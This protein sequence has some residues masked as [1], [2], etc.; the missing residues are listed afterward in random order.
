MK[1]NPQSEQSSS[2]SS[3]PPSTGRNSFVPEKINLG[4]NK[5]KI[6]RGRH[7]GVADGDDDKADKNGDGGQKKMVGTT[8]AQTPLSS[9]DI[10]S[11]VVFHEESIELFDE[12]D[13]LYPHVHEG[14]KLV[15]DP[16]AR[17]VVGSSTATTTSSSRSMMASSL[18]SSLQESA[19]A[20]SGGQQD[21]N[22]PMDLDSLVASSND[23]TTPSSYRM[24]RSRSSNPSAPPPPQRPLHQ[25]Y[26]R[27]SCSAPRGYIWLRRT[28]RIR[29]IC[30]AQTTYIP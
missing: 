14:G 22:V 5:G 27:C 28:I 30:A 25:G 23:R 13:E 21:A 19:R 15:S 17:S 2:P 8:S 4:I 9:S 6:R 24:A 12:I 18:L 26:C 10:S 20:A 29:Q 3:S 11:S 1:M 16:H 7:R